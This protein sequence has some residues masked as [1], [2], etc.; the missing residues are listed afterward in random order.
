MVTKSIP[1]NEPKRLVA[2]KFLGLLLLSKDIEEIVQ[3]IIIYEN[4]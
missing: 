1:A 3:N 4:K 2:F